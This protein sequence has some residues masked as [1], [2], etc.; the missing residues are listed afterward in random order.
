MVT[1]VRPLAAWLAIAVGMLLIGML[2]LR[3]SWHLVAGTP[4]PDSAR[5]V[6]HL[7][8]QKY[9]VAFEGAGVL[10]LIGIFG[11]VI[12]ARPSAYPDDPSRNARVAIDKRPLAIEDDRLKPIASAADH[13]RGDNP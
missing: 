10:I 2:L 7:L 9:M 1:P 13:P 12:L 6:G 11:A 8:M 5:Q 3:P 4:D